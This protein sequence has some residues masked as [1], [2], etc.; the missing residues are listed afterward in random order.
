MRKAIQLLLLCCLLLAPVTSACAAE[1]APQVLLLYDSLAKGGSREGNI[2]EM[3]RLLAAFGVK[4]TLQSLD[5]YQDGMMKE[6][7]HVITIMNSPEVTV[8]SEPYLQ[9]WKLY[10]GQYLHIGYQFPSSVALQLHT[11]TDAV[12]SK[13]IKI[14]IGEL[15]SNYFRAQDMLLLTSW[16]AK[17][18][19]YG[20]VTLESSKETVPYA[21]SNGEYTYVPYLEAGNGSVLAMTYVLK[22]WLAAPDIPQTYL[23]IREVY[24]FSDLELLETMAD[25]LYALG[26]PFVVSARPVFSNTDYPAMKRYL[27][28]LKAVQAHNGS[29]IINAPAVMF[30]TSSGE[31]ALREKMAGFI[32]V[33]AEN[34][35]AP[36]G[37]GAEMYWSYDTRYAA[38]GMGFFNSAVLFPDEKVMA[39]EPSNTSALFES[40]L[41]SL[42]EDRVQEMQGEDKVMPAYPLNTAITVKFPDNQAGME[43]VLHRLEGYWI[44]F[45]DYKQGYH[46][47]VSGDNRITS[48]NGVITINGQALTI[49]HAPGTVDD[50]YQY[51]AESPQSF[52]RLFSVQNRFFIAVILL[53]LLLFGGLFSVG[54]RLHRKKY[55]K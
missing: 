31:E 21:V 11:R 44:S 46:E 37:I 1:A 41:Y 16:D 49:Q 39:M 27:E 54:Y 24:P 32:S 30:S 9:D 25:R 14:A 53:S 26:I 13:N 17:A 43:E 8:V 6:Y 10:K 51:T 19:R 20:Y 42:P 52:A 33:L 50:S 47:T 55:L 2:P 45:A 36:L 4:V 5:K 29:I 18:Q 48:S 34:G 35:I 38:A 7:D 3:Q 28:A 22:D 23:V 15:S 12:G 40:S